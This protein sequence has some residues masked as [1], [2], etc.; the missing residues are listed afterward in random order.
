[1]QERQ[2]GYVKWFDDSKGFGFIKPEDGKDV[3]VH[4]R[5]IDG[6]GRKSLRENDRVEFNITEGQRGPQAEDVTVVESA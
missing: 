1:M 4:H 6:Q 5:A 3:F 2:K